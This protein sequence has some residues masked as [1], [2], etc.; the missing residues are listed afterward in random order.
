M[1]FTAKHLI[2]WDHMPG[3][4]FRTSPG[5]SSKTEFGFYMVS[6]W[7]GGKSWRWQLRT[8]TGFLISEDVWEFGPDFDSREEATLAADED[9][10]NRQT[11]KY[12]S[13]NIPTVKVVPPEQEEPLL[14]PD[15][16]KRNFNALVG[17]LNGGATP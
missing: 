5:A 6:S 10:V 7:D 12:A 14:W 11:L 17:I 9:Y 8:K 1:G 4:A 2:V 13:E 15:R 3:T 16:D